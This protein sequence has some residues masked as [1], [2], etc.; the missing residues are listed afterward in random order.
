MR[1]SVSGNKSVSSKY[2]SILSTITNRGSLSRSY[3]VSNREAT[4][5]GPAGNS[6]SSDG[7]TVA[8]SAFRTGRYASSGGSLTKVYAARVFRA[9]AAQPDVPSTTAAQHC[10]KRRRL[11]ARVSA[12]S[13]QGES[14]GRGPDLGKLAEIHTM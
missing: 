11:A 14:I 7:N 5:D 9:R 8:T 6:A 13:G 10:R 2:R 12:V 3:I 1:G 4:A